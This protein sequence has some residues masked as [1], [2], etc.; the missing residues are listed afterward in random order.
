MARQ[1]GISEI[2]TENLFD[3]IHA[4]PRWLAFLRKVGKAPEQLAKIEFKVTLPAAEGST[5]SGGANH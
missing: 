2:V 5:V 1:G 4:D 3:K